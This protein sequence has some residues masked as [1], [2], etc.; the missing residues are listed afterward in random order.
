MTSRFG[1]AAARLSDRLKALD[2]AQLRRLLA[3]AATCPDLTSFGEHLPPR[4]RR[5]KN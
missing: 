2:E 5:R 1:D 3:V 4:R